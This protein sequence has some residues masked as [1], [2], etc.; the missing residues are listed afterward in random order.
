MYTHEALFHDQLRAYLNS[1][2]VS[3]SA[4]Y[5][6][7]ETGTPQRNTDGTIS[8]FYTV[9]SNDS[10]VT[11]HQT[12]DVALH[13][14]CI[15]KHNYDSVLDSAARNIASN[16]ATTAL[17]TYHQ[18]TAACTDLRLHLIDL[19]TQTIM[20]RVAAPMYDTNKS[21]TPEKLA[22]DIQHAFTQR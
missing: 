14:Q 5:Y 18:P 11:Q 2:A 6:A 8:V 10:A 13:V 7:Q 4:D 16:T 21:I 22:R 19:S 20:C 3:D 15:L 12:R 9:T 17:S 1:S